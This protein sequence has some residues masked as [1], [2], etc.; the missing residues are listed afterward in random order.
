MAAGTVALASPAAAAAALVEGDAQNGTTVRVHPGDRLTVTLGS[1]AW[2][3]DAPAGSAVVATGPQTTAVTR[4][5]PGAPGTTSRP[6]LA[7]TVGTATL[8]ASRTTCGEALQC[9][10]A[11]GHWSMTVR[12]RA[13]AVPQLPH[14]GLPAGQL[15]LLAA[16]L[17][18]VGSCAVVVGRRPS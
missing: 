5:G 13:V 8:T 4:P 2:T 10:P 3:I 14:T 17:L 6:F 9:T 1:V 11:Q 12:V 18:V 15:A 16:G 7:R